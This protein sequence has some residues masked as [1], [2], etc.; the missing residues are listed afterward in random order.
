M[1]AARL[2][3]T[4]VLLVAGSA[5]GQS[6]TPMAPEQVASE[7]AR[8]ASERAAIATR[9]AAEERACHQRFAVNDC[10]NRN[11]AWQREALGALRRQEILINDSE[12]QRRAAERL[13]SLEDK[14]RAQA[15]DQA[16][17]PVAEPRSPNAA[18]RPGGGKLPQSGAPAP[19][20]PD[21]AAIR[22]HQE[23]MEHKQ[24]RHA[25]AQ[26]ERAEKAA[27][28]DEEARRNAARVREAEERKAS[29]LRRN[30]AEPSKAKPLP[31]P[32]P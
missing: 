27:L 13:E 9:F 11:R 12:R 18:S 31:D 2:C 24:Q 29:V 25:Q 6:S 22:Q 7:R 23:R 20:V 5:F 19:R 21:E 16:E 17:R 14:S 8:I 10:L 3:F 32:A 4:A 26:A 1:K 30:A 15:A 28:A